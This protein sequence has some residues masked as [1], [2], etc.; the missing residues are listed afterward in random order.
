[1]DLCH[2]LGFYLMDVWS[3]DWDRAATMADSKTMGGS[4]EFREA[5]PERNAKGRR[6]GLLSAR[7]HHGYVQHQS[8]PCQHWG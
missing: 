7:V 1:M 3:V 2:G 5:V 6:D 8:A 4:S